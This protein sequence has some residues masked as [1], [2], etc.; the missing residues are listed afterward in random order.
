[1]HK[2]WVKAAIKRRLLCTVM[3]LSVRI[4]VGGSIIE[5]FFCLRTRC[6]AVVYEIVCSFFFHLLF[7]L[8]RKKNLTSCTSIDLVPAVRFRGYFRLKPEMTEPPFLHAKVHQSELPSSMKLL[9]SPHL[10]LTNISFSSS[11]TQFYESRIFC[12]FTF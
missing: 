2:Q 3:F 1:M 11:N 9:L 4:C 10:F 12:L 8:D 5:M 6:F 7:N